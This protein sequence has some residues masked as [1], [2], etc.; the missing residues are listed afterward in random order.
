MTDAP[1]AIKGHGR[2]RT[3]SLW[4]AAWKLARDPFLPELMLLAR[5]LK[6][7]ALSQ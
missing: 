4:C 6:L 3:T 5:A 1:T 2:M 7:W